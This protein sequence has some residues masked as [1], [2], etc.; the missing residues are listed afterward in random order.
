MEEVTMSKKWFPTNS[1]ASVAGAAILLSFAALPAHAQMPGGSYAETCTNVQGWGGRLVAECRR[2]DG[3]WARTAL[4]IN[5]CTGDISNQNGRLDCNRGRRSHGWN[6]NQFEGYGG[7]SYSP[8]G[9]GHGY[10]GDSY[11]GR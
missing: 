3:S 6:R 4:D 7:S 2:E 1:A 5:G 8:Y 10:R 11:Y 9:Y